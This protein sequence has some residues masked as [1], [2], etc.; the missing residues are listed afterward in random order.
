MHK[1]HK[2][3]G[4]S[5]QGDVR[6]MISADEVKVQARI[7]VASFDS[8]NSNRDTNMQTV[9]EANKFPYV[10]LKGTGKPCALTKGECDVALNANVDF[11]GVTKPYAVTVHVKQGE[12]GKLLASFK[13]DVSVTAHNI[14]RPSL[15]LMPIDDIMVIDGTAEMEKTK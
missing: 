6:A 4:T 3:A 13:F 1:L 5:P 8:Q 2:F 9:V 7:P 11:H 12:G 15:M 14:E 10:T